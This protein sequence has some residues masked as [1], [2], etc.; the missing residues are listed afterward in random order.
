MRFALS[1]PGRAAALLGLAAAAI[2]FFLSWVRAAP[3]REIN[4]LAREMSPRISQCLIRREPALID[5]WLRTLPGSPLEERLVRSAEPRFS[6]CFGMPYG[7]NGAVWLPKYDKAG[8]RAALVRALLHARRHDLPGAATPGV[9]ASW[10]S[11]PQGSRHTPEDVA[12]IVA[13]DLGACLARKHW[14]EVL[15]IVGAVD[16]EAEKSIG[17]GWRD[18]QAARKREAAAVDSELSKVIPS[19]SACVPTGARLRI[20]R[21]RLRGLLEEAAYQMT[22]EDPSAAAQSAAFNAR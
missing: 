22:K 2:A 8:M 18:G 9:G 20:N 7:I 14:A 15:A 6:P 16:P 4:S 3:P 12:A 13:A 5:R 21:L 10:Y 17:W 1:T 19:V 11:F